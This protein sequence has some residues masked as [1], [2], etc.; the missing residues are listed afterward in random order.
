MDIKLVAGTNNVAFQDSGLLLTDGLSEYIAQKLYIKFRFFLGEYYLDATEGIDY[1]DK[2]LVKNP[3][4]RVIQSVFRA[5]LAET[6]GVG[7]VI[8]LELLYNKITRE[9]SANW[10]VKLIDGSVIEGETA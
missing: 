9:L 10:T 5:K 7:E 8:K 3:N 6:D 1:I 2:V 4:I